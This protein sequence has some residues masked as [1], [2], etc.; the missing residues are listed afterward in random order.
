MPAMPSIPMQPGMQPA[1]HTQQRQPAQAWP[2]MPTM[3]QQAQ[4]RPAQAPRDWRPMPTCASTTQR[5]L[6]QL[7]FYMLGAVLVWVAVD[8]LPDHPKGTPWLTSTAQTSGEPSPSDGHPPSGGPS[9]ASPPNDEGWVDAGAEATTDAEER[10]KR[11][12][13]LQAE[14]SLLQAE[15]DAENG[16]VKEEETAEESPEDPSPSKSRKPPKPPKW[17]P[18]AR[19]REVE[20]ELGRTLRRSERPP[21]PNRPPPPPE[22]H[23]QGEDTWPPPPPIDSPPAPPLPEVSPSMHATPGPHC[24]PLR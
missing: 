5:T 17:D 22:D 12:A 4:H 6:T 24:M 19:L 1:W 11:I 16:E 14:L 7:V 23:T 9:P 20:A 10:S 2:T 3:P 15:V 8:L 18:R 13:A 21:V